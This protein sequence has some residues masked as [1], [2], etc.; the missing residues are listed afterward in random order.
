LDWTRTKG[1]KALASTKKIG[2]FSGEH[3][4]GGAGSK[5]EKKIRVAVFTTAVG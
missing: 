3:H 2:M 4:C 1:R 5:D